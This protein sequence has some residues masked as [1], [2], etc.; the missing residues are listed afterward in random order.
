MGFSAML[1][2]EYAVVD[3]SLIGCVMARLAS[4][5]SIRVYSSFEIYLSL[6]TGLN[7]T[8][9]I[10]TAESPD[11]WLPFSSHKEFQTILN[12]MKEKGLLISIAIFCCLFV[13]TFCKKSSDTH[14]M[15]VG[16]W[17]VDSAQ[18][19]RYIN[20]QFVY[21]TIYK[22]STDY[23]DYRTDNRLYRFWH[24][25][26]DTVSYSLKDLNGRTLIDYGYSAD[27]IISLTGNQLLFKNPQG[28]DCKIY[29]TKY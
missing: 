10:S 18:L 8:Q 28:S 29:F 3:I 4:A 27:T 7:V 25:N 1:A 6:V 12:S 23:Y 5:T 20:N 2:E 17:K 14:G 9:N 13:L 26:F 15:L 11:R 22:P 21:E 16:K 24:G 19:L